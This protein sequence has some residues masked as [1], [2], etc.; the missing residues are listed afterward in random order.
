VTT[1]KFTLGY[2]VG[3]ALNPASDFGPRLI[4]YIAGYRAPHVFQTGWWIYG[5]WLATL[6]GSIIGCSV[7][8]GFIFVGS[9]SPINYRISKRLSPRTKKLLVHPWKGRHSDL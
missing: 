3:T 8:D 4:A 1:L 6:A 5:P 7:Y 2:N 9:E